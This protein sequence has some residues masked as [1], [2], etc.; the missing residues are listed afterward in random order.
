L[1][2]DRDEVPDADEPQPTTFLQQLNTLACS[3]V[4]NDEAGFVAYQAESVFDIDETD[5]D[6]E[7]YYDRSRNLGGRAVSEGEEAFYYGTLIGGEQY[8]FV[9]GAGSD[10][11]AY[12]LE[13]RQAD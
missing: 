3:L 8:V 12:E 5:T 1:D 4:D 10:Q 9:I 13:V 7:S 6:D 2:W 11:G